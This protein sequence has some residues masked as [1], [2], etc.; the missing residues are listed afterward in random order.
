MAAGAR[1]RRFA[2]KAVTTSRSGSE[3]RD[4][5]LSPVLACTLSRGDLQA[6]ARRWRLLWDEAGLDCSKTGDGV[7]LSFRGE[8]MVEE[9]LRALVAVERDCCAW[10]RWEIRHENG[11]L[12][13]HVSSTG[14][15][16]AALRR[17]QPS[18]RD[19]SIAGQG[20]AGAAANPAGGI[21]PPRMDEVY[22]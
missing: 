12:A 21:V 6:Q 17:F 8:R 9:E 22:E 4:E 5:K 14:A 15:G 1:E 18:C 3:R 20:G 2:E 19:V 7:R 16:I 10:A 13:L 11:E